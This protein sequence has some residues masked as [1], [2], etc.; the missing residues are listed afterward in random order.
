M[1]KPRITLK[2]VAI[3][4]GVH[5]ST[6]SRAL[7]PA[8]KG[9]VTKKIANRIISAATDMGY[10]PNTF[11]Q[12]LKTNRSYTIGVL[13]PDLTN[14]AFAPIINGI[15]NMLE[16]HGY[17]VMVAST[18][19]LA[20]KQQSTLNKFRERQV[21]GLIIATAMRG[22]KLIKDCILEG[23][24]FV[25]AVRASGNTDVCS[26]ISDEITGG[27]MVISHLAQLG[28]KKIAYIAGPQFLSTGF[29][30]Y[31]GFLQG[32]KK[33]GLIV[34][35]NLIISCGA[36]S[37][38]EAGNAANKLLA[39]KKKITAIYVGNDI[40]ALGVYNE[41]EAQAIKCGK[42]ISVVGFDDMPFAN[43]FNPPL[44]TIHTPMINVGTEAA[45]ILLDKINEINIPAQIIKIKP[46]L[47]IR[48]SSGIIK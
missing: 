23:T 9:M 20:K 44:T 4:V 10:R 5:S 8:T 3:K 40:M 6:V 14:P 42:D 48:S 7:N 27:I 39:N 46:E 37:E 13:V 34:D 22:D 21:D 31:Q 11:A 30:R 12:S 2:D 18:Y 16:T 41:L 1:A 17:S 15:E 29:N 38:E 35:Q 32:M 19:N 25:E 43:K 28:H 47:I 24:P 33:N 26:V 45:R 36:F